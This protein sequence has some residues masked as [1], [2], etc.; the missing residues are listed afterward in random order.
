M[1][2]DRD[3]TKIV[4]VSVLFVIG[5]CSD[6]VLNADRLVLLAVF[7]AGYL[8]SA[9]GIFLRFVRN[10]RN[11][12]LFD[13]NLLMLIATLGAFAIGEYPEALAVMLFFNVGEMFEE[14]AVERSRKSVSALLDIVPDSANVV[15]GGE[16][17]SV[18]PEKV[19]VGETIIVKPGEKV[20]LDGVVTEGCSSFDTKTLTGESVPRDAGP[21][22]E[23]LAGFIDL[24]C[25]VTVRVTKEYGD[26]SAVRIMEMIEESASRKSRSERFI[27]VFARYYT[28]FVCLL[29]LT[30]AAFPILV[31]GLDSGTWTYRAL[32]LLVVSC[33]CAL[34]LS[35]PLGFFCGI[36]CASRFGILVK[37]GNYLEMLA[38]TDTVVFD[39]TGTLTKGT[40][41]VTDVHPD[42]ISEEEL[43][44][45]AA[46]AEFYSDH[47]ISAGIRERNCRAMDSSS[48]GVSMAVPGMGVVTEVEGRRIHAGS[49]RMMMD[50]GHAPRDGC[51]SGTK[52]HMASEDGYLGHIALSDTAKTDSEWTVGSLRGMGIRTVML[53]GDNREAAEGIADRLG[54][55]EVRY[56]LLPE[57]KLRILEEMISG[58]GGSTVFVG[59]GINDA[60]S[61]A[62]SDVGIAM[63][64]LGSDAAIDAADVVLLNDA[65]SNVVTAIRI[66][67]RTMRIVRQNI[68]FALA[69][70]AVII[71]LVSAGVLGMYAAVFGDVGVMVIAV[72]NAMRCLR[73]K[74]V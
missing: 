39:K 62:R 15:R 4:A 61:L 20:P 31:L 26:S 16:L 11:G 70:K 59:D 42:G 21:G 54:I 69:V 33:P 13:E 7:G 14:R 73:T 22:D 19:S 55:D 72:L 52:V 51:C 32:A 25:K 6:L 2:M 67:K 50:L 8:V 71:V 40:F 74:G 45:L 48:V 18:H 56:E 47:P 9:Y 27:T 46:K 41:S 53:T 1:R 49:S 23:I 17:V 29:A 34:V 37:G 63:G 3:I 30:V 65:P 57:D 60:P 36:G 24:S 12:T 5:L 43:V 58:S 38:K 68:V 66:S 35:I 44:G 64:G 28:P 10:I